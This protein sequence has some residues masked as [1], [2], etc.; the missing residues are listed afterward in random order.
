MT[1]L[2]ERLGHRGDG[3]ARGPVFAARTLPGETVTGDLD[4]DRLSNIRIVV[5][6]ADR[7]SPPCSHYKSCGGCALQHA[8]DDF[9]A[10]WKE[11]V[12]RAALAAQDIETTFRAAAISPPGSRRRA[13][14]TGHRTK[15]GA[16]VG[17]H[18]R[19]SDRVAAVPNCRVLT[20]AILKALPDLEAL[21]RLGASR[22][23]RIRL[24]VTDTETGLDIVVSDAKPLDR[25]LRIEL[26]TWC[27]KADPARLV[28]NTEQVAQL[29][30]PIVSFGSHMVS[31]PPGSFLQATAH[32]Q[33]ALVAAVIEMVEGAKHVVDLFSGCGTFA[34]PLAERTQVHAVEGSA[35]M[36]LALDHGWRHASGLKHVTTEAR[37]LFRRPLDRDDLARF[38]VAVIDP[39]RAGA[40]AQAIQLAASAIS[41][42]AFVSCDPV[43]FA[44]D[45][46]I[47]IRGGFR[48]EWVQ[49]VD[50][51]RWSP[52]I[53]LAAC[54]TR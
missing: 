17:F 30:A 44:R 13:T 19:A 11:D 4:G 41:R 15:K 22:A 23:S 28:W 10:S 51:F 9:V 7:V 42:I 2:I 5:P 27:N 50:Q 24:Q 49:M 18:A 34:L 53:E 47:L 37:D 54:F 40:E 35:Q 3:V 46:K 20:T 21:T 25:A 1:H 29:R 38:D 16:Q 12:I 26:A 39:P 33:A 43:T 48:L 52:H 45:A 31:P 6:S 14:L 8:A 36:L 32:G